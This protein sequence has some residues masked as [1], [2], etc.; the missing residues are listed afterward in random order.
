MTLL[1]SRNEV[2]YVKSFDST[3]ERLVILP[4]ED[5][6]STS[7]GRPIGP[8]YYDVNE[9]ISFMDVHGIDVSV[10]SLANPWLDWLPSSSATETARRI[11]D[12]TEAMCAASKGRLFAFA[13][14]PLSAPIEEVVGEV[15]RVAKLTHVRGVVMGSSGL[16]EG[17]D[18]PRLDPVWQSLEKEGMVIVGFIAA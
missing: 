7:R 6:A 5:T 1:R 17:L 13:T 15:G 9:K 10:I 12:D 4:A 14:L 3:G 18:D 8:E 2:P 11:N 16:G